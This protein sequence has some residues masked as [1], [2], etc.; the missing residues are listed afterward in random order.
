MRAIIEFQ[1]DGDLHRDVKD[2]SYGKHRLL[3]IARAVAMHP[4]VLLLDEPA[5]GLSTAESEEL[6]EVVRRLAQDW[7][8]AVLVVEHDMNFV[9]EVCDEV[10]VLDFGNKIAVG[11]PEEIRLDPAVVAAY[12][13]TDADERDSEAEPRTTQAVGGGA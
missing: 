11:S 4:S 6:A 13:G 3:A 5:A 9:N 8:M 10:V 2:L 7:G 1:L 12:L